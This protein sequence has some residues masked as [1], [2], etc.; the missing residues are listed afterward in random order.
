[1]TR[2]LRPYFVFLAAS[3]GMFFQPIFFLFYER[4]LGLGAPTILWLQSW[5]LVVRSVLDLPFGVLA[6]R[7]SRRACLAG[8]A[9]AQFAGVAVLL[10]FPG[11]AAALAAEIAFGMAAAL[12]SGADSAFL[13]DAFRAADD[14]AGYPA[15]ESRAQSLAAISSGA[16]AVIGGAVAAVDLRLPY[17][18]S[19]VSAV[20]A[21]VAALRLVEPPHLLRRAVGLRQLPRAARLAVQSPP[22][23]WAIALAAFA[24]TTSH[25]YF[26]LQQPFLAAIGAPVATFGLLFAAT[27][28]V[29]AVVAAVAHR[30]DEAV[31][32]R[33]TATAMTVA[34]AVGLGAM[35]LASA[36]W[37]GP[38]VLTR[39]V[40]DG[41][42]Q[43]LL[44]VYV[45]RRVDSNTRA[46]MLSLQSVIARLTLAATLALLGVVV[47]RAGVS[48]A[49]AC[50]GA[51][52]AVVGTLL[53]AAAP[54]RAASE[55]PSTAGRVPY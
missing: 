1:M 55:S 39:G 20:V 46:T 45:N 29:T 27:K 4:Q 31:G 9:A 13:F 48:A 16:A 43:P 12:R 25:V 35:S 14:T 15:A 42:W 11:L 34:P 54:S 32:E 17:L 28:L 51:T 10:T 37:A 19:L 5:G 40:L 3:N 38:L 36:A 24:V 44:N 53:V 41:L 18:L 33:G 2:S 52:A 22:L 50:A 6:D 30:I 8:T 49:L 7:R 47:Q 26:Y 23:R 21:A